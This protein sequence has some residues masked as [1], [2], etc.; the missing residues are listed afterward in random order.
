MERK[1][2]K[3]KIGKMTEGVLAEATDMTLWLFAYFAAGSMNFSRNT[4][5]NRIAADDFIS[6]IN[7]ETIKNSLENLRRKGY[8]KRNGRKKAWPEITLQGRKRLESILPEYDEKRIWDGKIYLLTY[9]IPEKRKQDREIL[10]RYARK[11]GMGMLLESVWITPYNPHEILAEYISKKHL[12][13]VIIVADI[14]KDGAIGDE[15][16]RSLV[17]RVYNLDRLNDLYG[18]YIKN[19]TSGDGMNSLQKQFGFLSILSSDPQLPWDLLPDDWQGDK[20]YKL[21]K[22]NLNKSL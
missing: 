16:L 19:I 11:L 14:G 6:K 9:D 5:R 1:I 18:E 21:Y 13:G 15:D 4:W 10:R 12:A 3:E 7:Y 22:E 20:A 17:G 8:I 2:L